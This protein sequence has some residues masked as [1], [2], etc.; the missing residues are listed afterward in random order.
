MLAVDQ[1]G[2]GELNY[3][4]FLYGTLD[5]DTHSLTHTHTYTH[6]HT[7][8]HTQTHPHTQTLTYT[9]SFMPALERL[10][11]NTGLGDNRVIKNGGF[12]SKQ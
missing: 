9:H 6:T 7:H 10:F 3:S 1:D 12:E 11:S 5:V 8:L 2:C 4:E